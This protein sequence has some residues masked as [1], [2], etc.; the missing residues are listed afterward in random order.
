[1][2]AAELV[3]PQTQQRI[4]YLVVILKIINELLRRQIKGGSPSRFALPPGELALVQEAPFCCRDKFLRSSLIIA[5]IGVSV[6][7]KRHH[8]RVV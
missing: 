7:R 2:R 6:S 3:G 8:R 5:V 4:G 1:M